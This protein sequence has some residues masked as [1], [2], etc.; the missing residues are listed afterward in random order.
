VLYNTQA[1]QAEVTRAGHNLGE[2]Y[3]FTGPLLRRMTAEQI[4]DS[5]V[6]LIQPTPDLPRRRGID[7][8][9]ADRLAHRGKLSDAL[10][11][12]SAQEIFNGS[13]KASAAYDLTAAQAKELR[14][15]F[16]AAQKAKD[17]QLMEKLNLEIRSLQFTARTA[18]HENV[19]VPAVARLYTKRTGQPAP[20]PKPVIK[21]KLEDLKKPG[22]M[23]QY[24]D[25][26]GYEKMQAAARNE[27]AAEEAREAIFQE[28]AKRFAIPAAELKGYLAA[29]RS[30]AREW[31][32][33]ADVD[34]PAPR[35][36]YLRE[37]GQ[38][39]RDMIENSNSDASMPQALV[40]MNSQLF[41]GMI[42][43]H[44]QLTVNLAAAKNDDDRIR[45]IYQTLLS[46]QPTEAEQNAW[47]NAQQSGLNSVEDLIYA[48]INT[49]Q[50]IFVQ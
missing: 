37:F 18:I 28:E 14:D 17:K 2:V 41:Q 48:L 1:Y 39:D 9:V 31:P 27:K 38:S 13:V 3:H 19:V 35:G 15:K 11:L 24:I 26:P 32:R 30:Q 20:P 5:F 23:W 29:R 42:K 40:L 8:E 25:V 46:R 36:H 47:K 16:T 4:Y 49:Q 12:L 22:Q 6:T 43:P 21:P 34:S 45:I 7:S 10:D 44:T 33:A 50:F